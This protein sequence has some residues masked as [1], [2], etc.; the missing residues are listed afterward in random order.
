MDISLILLAIFFVLICLICYSKEAAPGPT[1]FVNPRQMSRQVCCDSSNQKARLCQDTNKLCHRQAMNKPVNE[2]KP[3]YGGISTYSLFKIRHL[4]NPEEMPNNLIGWNDL[5]NERG[6]TDRDQNT[7]IIGSD[8]DIEDIFTEPSAD[9]IYT[10][11]IPL[12]V[13]HLKRNMNETGYAIAFKGRAFVEASVDNNQRPV[14]FKY[15][16]RVYWYVLCAYLHICEC[17]SSFP[18]LKSSQR[19]L[20]LFDQ[21]KCSTVIPISLRLQLH[22]YIYIYIVTQINKFRHIFLYA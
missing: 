20:R 11:R 1:G 19:R 7:F 16:K 6:L 9:D 21:T 5:M 12:R 18:K 8:D 4:V 10:S 2:R 3:S 14:H 17:G 22:K 13:V 15:H